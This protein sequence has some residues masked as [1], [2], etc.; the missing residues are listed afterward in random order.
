MSEAHATA[1]PDLAL[2]HFELYVRDAARMEA[3]Y[4]ACLGFIVT[5]RGAGADAMVFLSRNAGEHHQLVLNPR[6]S[7]RPTDSPLDHISFRVADLAGVRRFYQALRA[8]AGVAVDAVSHGST[9]SIYFRDP[10]GNRLEV[11]ADTP[12]HVDQPCRFAIDLERDDAQLLA[13]T[14]QQL[15]GRPGFRPVAQ[16]RREH[17]EAFGER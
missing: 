6:P 8:E 4:T 15:R 10:E 12:W 2:S 3:F 5:D 11:F 1:F 9:W 16:W 13:F 14:E 7:G 17:G